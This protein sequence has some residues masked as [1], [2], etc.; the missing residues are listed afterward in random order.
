MTQVVEMLERTPTDRTAASAR[1][2]RSRA[3]RRRGLMV[4]RIEAPEYQLIQAL[5][6]AGRLDEAGG[7]D[8]ARVESA[9]ERLVDDFIRR[10]GVTRGLLR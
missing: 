10:W 7:M 5:Q 6:L 2:R 4:L 3:R 1:Q 8:R 9:V